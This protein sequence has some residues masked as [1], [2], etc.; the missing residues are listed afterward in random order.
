MKVGLATADI[1]PPIGAEKPGGFTKAHNRGL[2]D[3]LYVKAMVLDDGAKRA[4][5]VSVDAL[6]LKASIVRSAR[7]AA[8]ELCGIPESHIMCAATHTH[9]GGPIVGANATD[10]EHASDPGFCRHLAIECSVTPDPDYVRHVTRQIANAV[11]L[12]DRAK[13]PALLAVGVGRESNVTF[14]RRFR[15]RSGRQVT[16]PGKGNPDIIGP[17][18]PVDPDVGVLSAWTPDGRF[19]GGI[20]NFACHCT[21]MAG[22]AISADWPYFLNQTIRRVMGF[23]ST[24]L[25]LNGPCGDISQID[26]MSLRESETGE[27]W[28]RRVGQT[29]AAEAVKVLSHAEL[30]KLLPVDVTHET[31]Q[32]PTRQVP[33][34]RVQQALALLKSDAPTDHEWLFARD[35]VLLSE[36]NKIEPT[37]K[38]EIQ[39]IQVG[40]AVLVSD[41]A[42]YFAQFGLDIKAA[43]PFPYTLVV[44]QANGCIGYVP[45]AAAMGE[46]GGGYETRM[47]L[48]S[49]LVPEAGESIAQTSLN[50]IRSLTPSRPPEPAEPGSSTPWAMGAAG[51]DAT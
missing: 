20:V 3:R 25:F 6:S 19:L 9:S 29:V 16:H 22:G 42:E 39:A 23:E 11:A 14:N 47:A 26:N 41:P 17:A 38:C 35:T 49:K 36:M 15:M 8:R 50:V 5:I 51:P 34:E 18:G 32:I 24:V 13:A 31:I 2:H 37:V 1:T 46:S 48:S 44:E 7:Q 45:T 12:A 4:A 40:P 10:F 27:K 21:T 28:A 30:A 43:S 33:P